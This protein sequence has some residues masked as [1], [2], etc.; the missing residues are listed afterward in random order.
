MTMKVLERREL[1]VVGIYF[2]SCA[3]NYE[4][5]T[6]QADCVIDK[7][8]DYNFT[9]P[10]YFDWESW[11]YFNEYNVSFYSL[12]KIANIFI[13]K[14]NDNGYES[15]LYSSKYYLDNI[16]YDEKYENIWLAQYNDEVTYS[17]KYEYWQRCNTGR[18]SGINGDVD[19]DIRE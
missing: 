4:D 9:L 8:K 2:Y 14:L 5:A 7:I 19:I 10:V 12:N 18:I 17:G 16:W 1:S 3:N 11:S 6:K 15:G 13:S